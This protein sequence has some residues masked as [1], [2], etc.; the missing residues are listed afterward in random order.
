MIKGKL[1]HLVYI[2]IHMDVENSDCGK[3]VKSQSF[4]YMSD[5]THAV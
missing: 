2:R 4:G 3:E 5:V 1:Y